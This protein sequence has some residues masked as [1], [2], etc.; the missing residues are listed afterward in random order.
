MR[1]S[2][3]PPPIESPPGNRTRSPTLLGAIDKRSI[4]R[5]SGRRQPECLRLRQRSR[6]ACPRSQ[7]A[8]G[9]CPRS[10]SSRGAR[11]RSRPA[12]GGHKGRGYIDA[13]KIDSPWRARHLLSA[14]EALR[15]SRPR[16]PPGSH[17]G[18]PSKAIVPGLSRHSPAPPNCGI[19]RSAG[20]FSS[21]IRDSTLILRLPTER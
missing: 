16:Q 13:E 10:Q 18:S 7:V 20:C 8:A 3:S 1:D 9:A 5:S 12:K 15:P 21:R 17:G 4:G 14:G 11:P 6:G 19:L 2:E